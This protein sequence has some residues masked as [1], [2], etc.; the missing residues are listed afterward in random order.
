MSKEEKEQLDVLFSKKE[1][2]ESGLHYLQYFKGSDSIRL[3]DK[4]TGWAIGTQTEEIIEDIIPDIVNAIEDVFVRHISD[5][6]A[7]IDNITVNGL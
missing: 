7:K 6:Q 4:K 3:E 2:L 1:N 5:I